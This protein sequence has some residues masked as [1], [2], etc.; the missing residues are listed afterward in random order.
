MPMTN[1]LLKMLSSVNQYFLENH[2]TILASKI[3]LKSF[4]ESYQKILEVEKVSSVL[5]VIAGDSVEMISQR[6][7]DRFDSEHLKQ[8]IGADIVGG[9]KN[10]QAITLETYFK[11]VNNNDLPSS[12][13][14]STSIMDYENFLTLLHENDFFRDYDVFVL[15]L[16][17]DSIV[18]CD[19]L[20]RDCILSEHG[21]VVRIF[22]Y[23]NRILHAEAFSLIQKCADS[24]CK[25]I[26]LY[27]NSCN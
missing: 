11:K 2:N 7:P 22:M 8:F 9:V 19:D 16:N 27:I 12:D 5:G 24:K 26:P 3:S 15:R 1:N 13:D 17:N 6:F 20:M 4:V 14:F 25:V 18:H 23:P 21:F 10:D